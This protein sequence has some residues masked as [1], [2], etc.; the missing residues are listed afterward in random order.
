VT[1]TLLGER[2]RLDHLIGRGGMAAVWSATDTVLGRPVAVKR[3]HSGL[4]ADREHSE[5]FRREAM[6]VARLSHPNLVHLL[7]RG[8]DVEGP[9]LVMEL[10]DGEN[11]KARIRRDGP[12]PPDEAARVCAEVARALGYAHRQGVVHRDI[13][14]Q[15]VLLTGDGAVKLADF[16][17]ARLIETEDAEGLTRTDML[18][19][20][21]DYLSP[22]QADGRP[23][24]A[25]TDIYSLGILLYECLTGAMPFRGEGFVAVAMKHCSE[26]M[27][28]PRLAHP[29]VPEWLAACACRA[30]AKEPGDRF[31]TAEAMVAAL[32]GRGTGEGGTLVMPAAAP[33]PVVDEPEG[34]TARR[35]RPRRGALAALSITVLVVAA[36]VAAVL[37]LGLPGR[38]DGAS[39]A[40]AAPVPLTIQAVRDDDPQGDGSENPDQRGL[41]VDGKPDTAWYTEHYRDTPEFGGLK[42]GV[43]LIVRL[44]TPAVATEMVVSSP[45]PGARFQ[46]LGREQGGERPVLAEA[47]FT[48]QDQ[49]VALKRAAPSTSYVLWITELVPDGTGKF[50][51]GVGEVAFRGVPNT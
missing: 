9:Y 17:I 45:T 44:S 35:R 23:I 11:L 26:P 22:E 30:A 25:R 34:D 12:L 18:L 8:E 5:R 48:G 28:D 16:G 1:E 49:R 6:L 15:N 51:A 39:P 31:P 27:P 21:A 29:D 7:D 32:E 3:L 33:P 43:G 42:S 41:A 50:W 10:I 4:L 19:G 13:K 38:D 40:A 24:D 20:S 2:Y 46:V 14:A 47:T 36:A 37:V